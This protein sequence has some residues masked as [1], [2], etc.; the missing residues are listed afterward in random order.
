MNIPYVMK[1]CKTCGEWLVANNYNFSKNKDGK[2]GLRSKCKKCDKKWRGNNKEYSKEYSKEWNKNN[3]EYIKKHKKQYYKDNKEYIKEKRKQYYKD[4]KEYIKE[5]RKQY[6]ENNK[7]HYNKYNK[8]WRKDNPEKILKYNNKRRLK[9]ENQGRDITKEQW[10]EM[11]DFFE[12][13]CAYSGE[14]LG[15]DSDKR[16]IDHIVALDNGGEH[17]IWNLVPMYLNYNSSKNKRI[18]VLNWY[19]EQEYFDIERLDKIVKWQIYAFNKWNREEFGE[20]VLITDL[21][22]D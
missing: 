9:K 21:L 20:L 12:W 11:M 17:E 2:W 5:Y 3:E 14:Y 6:R 4:N 18:D 22:E 1:K 10:K 19:L 16:T 8:E 15:G 7:E 13:K